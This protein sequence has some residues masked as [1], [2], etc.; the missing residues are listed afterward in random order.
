VKNESV[1]SKKTR[2]WIWVSDREKETI[3]NYARSLHLS[4]SNFATKLLLERISQLPRLDDRSRAL[5]SEI[6]K[7][8]SSLVES[9]IRLRLSLGET[10]R[11]ECQDLLLMFEHLIAAIDNLLHT[12]DDR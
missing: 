2:I 11:Q 6:E 1:S 3:K 5:L 7:D 4:I 12:N 10:Q 8:F 9:Y